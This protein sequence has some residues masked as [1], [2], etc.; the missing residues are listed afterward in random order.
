MKNR[1]VY[2][3]LL[4]S[5]FLKAEKLAAKNRKTTAE[6]DPITD[7]R[8]PFSLTEL[9]HEGLIEVQSCVNQ[10]MLVQDANTQELLMRS[11]M[12]IAAMIDSYDSMID[13]S[14]LHAIYR[15]DRDYLQSLIDRIDDMI[16]KLERGVSLSD[17]DAQLLQQNI[18]QLQI[19]RNKLKS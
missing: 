8:A 15:D 4:I 6:I 14:K 16:A 11:E 10:M 9:L 1:L 12:T 2:Y 13:S 17:T 5:Y 7:F 19:L 18:D 3:V